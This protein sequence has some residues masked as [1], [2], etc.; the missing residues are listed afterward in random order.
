MQNNVVTL[1]IKRKSIQG[2]ETIYKINKIILKFVFIF[3]FYTTF[4]KGT[5]TLKLMKKGERKKR[6][7]KEQ[8]IKFSL[9]HPK[10]YYSYLLA[11]E[12]YVVQTSLVESGSFNLIVSSSVV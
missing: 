7:K 10:K 2:T 8:N 9:F 5:S 1:F 6:K 11:S 3:Y 12:I 4:L